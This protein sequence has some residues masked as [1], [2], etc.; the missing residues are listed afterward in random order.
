MVAGT[1]TGEKNESRGKQRPHLGEKM[2]NKRKRIRERRTNALRSG[3]IYFMRDGTW[4]IVF[5]GLIPTQL[6]ARRTLK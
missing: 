3:A 6:G 2:T 1:L 5:N 4:A